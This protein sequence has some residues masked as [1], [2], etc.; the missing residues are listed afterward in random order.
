M[1]THSV[2]IEFVLRAQMQSGSC[3]PQDGG[4]NIFFRIC[5]RG[6]VFTMLLK[7]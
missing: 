6:R 5:T 7:G 3:V 2:L 4:R 1:C